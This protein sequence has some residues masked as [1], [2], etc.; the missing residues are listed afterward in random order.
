MMIKTKFRSVRTNRIG[1]AISKVTGIR[2]FRVIGFFNKSL[3]LIQVGIALLM[4]INRRFFIK[5]YNWGLLHIPIF[6]SQ[7]I[8]VGPLNFGISQ[9]NC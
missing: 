8:F 4:K 5:G 2:H 7:K 3:I 9:R 1:L 6:L